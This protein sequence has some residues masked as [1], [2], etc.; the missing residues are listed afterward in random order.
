MA[1]LEARLA[2]LTLHHCEIEA[3]AICQLLVRRFEQEPLLPGVVILEQGSPIGMV[4]RRR[5]L[6]RLSLPHHFELLPKRPV[7]VLLD[8]VCPEPLCLPGALMVTEAVKSALTR[9][10]ELA[11]EPIVVTLSHRQLRLLD[12]QTLLLAH[13]RLHELTSQALQRQQAQIRTYWQVLQAEQMRVQDHTSR[14]VKSQATI[15]QHRQILQRQQAAVKVQAHEVAARQRSL[16][17]S[18]CQLVQEGEQVFQATFV[19]IKAVHRSTRHILNTS[20]SFALDLEEIKGMMEA[21][22]GLSGHVRLLAFS[23]AVE[24]H[25]AGVNGQGFTRIA[26][27]IRSLVDRLNELNQRL[28]GFQGRIQQRSDSTTQAASE[29]VGMAKTLLGQA[30]DARR[31]LRRIESLLAEDVSEDVSGE[32]PSA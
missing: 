6:E 28:C 13:A 31:A 3:S 4:S 7:G 23:S 18:A 26:R 17:D 1:E 29:G 10:A 9:P 16:I 8:P 2:H 15:S 11:Y 30:R 12:M 14:L 5:F 32:T 21:L 24:A 25:R 27:E 20:Q 22:S 19:G